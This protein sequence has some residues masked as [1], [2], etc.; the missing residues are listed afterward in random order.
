MRKF[1]D[2]IVKHRN[3]VYIGIAVLLV[4]VLF[5]FPVLSVSL[6]KYSDGETL[7]SVWGFGEN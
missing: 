2:G 3:F 5:L 6:G 7:Y 1:A 4:L